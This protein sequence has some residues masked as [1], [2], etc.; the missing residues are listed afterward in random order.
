ML[1]ILKACL[2]EPAFQL[3]TCS[4]AMSAMSIFKSGTFDIVMLDVVM[5]GIDGFELHTLIRNVSAEIP[6]IMLT[7]KVDD[8]DGTMLKKISS[9]RNTYY[10]SK[11]FKRDDLVAKITNIIAEI[12]S[13]REKKKYFEEMEKDAALAGEVQH[14]MFPNWDV[15]T[16]CARHCF[17]YRP[18]MQITGDI[19]S[20]KKFSENKFLVFLGDVSGHGIQAALWM[21]AVEYSLANLVN[22]GAFDDIAPHE[23]LNYLQS[24]MTGIASDR[25]MTCLVGILDFDTH[26]ISFQ[27]AGHPDF[28][29]YTPSEAKF[30]EPNPDGKGSLPVGLVRGTKYI[31]ED[32][33][34]LSFPPDSIIFAYTDGLTDIQDKLGKTYNMNPLREFVEAFSKNGLGAASVFK[35][36]DAL[37]KMGFDDVTDDISL[38]SISEY[39]RQ[40]DKMDFIIKPMIS[41][42]DRFAQRVSKLVTERYG[43]DVLGS[44]VEI[45]LSEFLNNVVVHGLDNRNASRPVI[46]VHIEFREKDLAFYFYDMGKRWDMHTDID[47][48][49]TS[50]D[51]LNYTRATSGRGLSIIKKIT[52]SIRRNRYAGKL[53][54][55]I[56]TVGF[57]E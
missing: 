5:P 50:S 30:I 4:D 22:G 23:V 13:A 26:S 3:T 43:N 27:N 25:Y 14:A 12:S 18:Y 20:V 51:I 36:M 1:K 11:T 48:E 37:S 57:E 53:N 41:E 56:F 32:S 8:I 47:D 49:N 33:V 55:T 24:F 6:I 19:F 54:E 35:I 44:K 38:V 52:S 17:Y 42:V 28:L 39:R 15:I 2:V 46:S 31:E 16:G 7:A 10:Q 40:K 9:D 45:L 34:R 21:S 29:L